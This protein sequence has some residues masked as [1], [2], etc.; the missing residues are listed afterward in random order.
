MKRFLALVGLATLSGCS[1]I[2]ATKSLLT[3]DYLLAKGSQQLTFFGDNDHPRFSA[4]GKKILFTSQARPEHKGAQIYELEIDKN[5]LRRVTYSD[6]DAFDATYVSDSEILYASTTDEIKESPILNKNFS[7]ESPPAEL[8][9]S[10]LYGTDILRLT[11]QPGYDGEGLFVSHFSRPAIYFT[12]RRGDV[13]GIYRMDLKNLPVTVIGSEMGHEKRFPTVT[14]DGL[15]MAF[16]DKDLKTSEQVVKVLDL[17]TRVATVIKKNDGVYRDLQFAPQSPARLFYSVLR[18]GE[19]HYQIE[20]YDLEKKCT[21][22]VFKGKDS[23]VAPTVSAT[24]PEKM[25]FARLIEDK[26]QIYILSLPTD[27]GPCIEATNP[28]NL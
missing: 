8:Y 13:V 1:T 20:V 24:K 15:L 14:S 22:V 25:A 26:K 18:K 4:D 10:D 16:V 9:M 27:L 5:K 6:G 17:K 28:A 11:Y 3:N 2:K 12:T 23:L 19:V 21:Q 7:K